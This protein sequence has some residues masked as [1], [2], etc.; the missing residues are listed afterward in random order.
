MKEKNLIR[1]CPICQNKRGS[2]LYKQQFLLPE[3]HILPSESDIVSCSHCGFVFADTPASQQTYDQYYTEMSKYEEATYVNHDS[4]LFIDRADWISSVVK[5]K[6]SSII[7]I[8]CGNGQ[9][10]LELKKLGFSN[11]TAL[12]PSSKCI[13]AIRQQGISGIHSSVFDLPVST[14]YDNAILSG[15]LEHICDITGIIKRLKLLL[16]QDSLLHV[17][18]PDAARYCEY[19]TIPFDYFNIEHIN[20]FD[21]TSLYNVGFAFG[22]EIVNFIK[23]EITIGILS[24][25]IIFCS[26]CNRNRKA[27]DWSGYSHRMIMEYIDRTQQNQT[28]NQTIAQLSQSGEEII[29]WGAGNYTSR[30]L[31]DSGLDKCNI[32]MFVDNDKHKQGNTLNNKPVCPSTAI[33]NLINNPTIVVAA[34]IFVDEIIGEIKNMRLPNQIV[35]LK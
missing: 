30:L 12:D 13:E 14:K 11:L 10:L 35:A 29:V 9:L 21:E 26:Y 16:N 6:K 33:S 3:T 27:I 19:D 7:D 4:S 17:C 31:T 8:G 34:A 20:H 22:L 25:P 15:V 5:D 18:V 24:Q 28:I 32:V 23:T 1:S 2:V